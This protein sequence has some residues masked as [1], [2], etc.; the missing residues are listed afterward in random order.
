MIPDDPDVLR[1][2][3]WRAIDTLEAIRALTIAVPD[4]MC[5]E[6]QTALSQIAQE[7][8]TWDNLNEL[9]DAS[10]TETPGETAD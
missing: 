7:I 2:E 5:C 8:K 6:A 4:E 3:L 1:T 9:V 10:A